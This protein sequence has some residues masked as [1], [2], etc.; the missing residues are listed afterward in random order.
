[1]QVLGK[2]ELERERLEPGKTGKRD[3]V[4]SPSH[5]GP[6]DEMNGVI[7]YCEIASFLYKLLLS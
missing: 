5:K 7:L 2:Y 1:M 6:G 4:N 3:S